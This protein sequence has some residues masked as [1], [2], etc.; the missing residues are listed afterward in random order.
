M[1]RAVLLCTL[2]CASSVR[3]TC[4]SLCECSEAAQTVKCVSKDLREIPSGIPGY[5]RNLFILGNHITRIGPESFKGLEN[6]T[7]L[8]LSN[9]RIAE[10]ES[11]AFGG[12]RSLRSLDLSGNQLT[13][14]HPEALAV[15]SGPLRD[16]NLSRA[17]YNHSALVDLATALRWG[18]LGSLQQLDLSA[19]RL[20][21]LPPA[22]FAHLPALRR[23]L[24]AN[25]SLVA[26]HNGT[27]LGL[28]LLDELD[29]TQ[30]AFRTLRRGALRELDGLGGARLLL[31][32][33]PF[34]CTCGLEDFI[35]WLNGTGGRVADGDQLACAFPLD[36]HNTSLRGL[37]GRALGC[38][39]D[40]AGEGADLALQTSYVFLGVVLGFVGVVFLFV[41]YLNRKGIK[42]W[43]TDVREAC[44]DILEGYHYRY[45]MDSDPR[46]GQLSTSADL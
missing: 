43:V 35:A 44:R 14:I 31:G 9:N 16:L 12:L 22:M 2:L 19:N 3:A 24:L 39:G 8:S 37:G 21:L 13:L 34:T 17:L 42:R 23:L 40:T 18:M 29:L 46:L 38:H 28:E 11:Q 5:T 4:P 30:N 1:F 10:V 15:P 36:L 27:F 6:V 41:L 45:E 7:N 26:L 25:N 20:V 32:G 33:N